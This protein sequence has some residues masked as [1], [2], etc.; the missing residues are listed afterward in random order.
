MLRLHPFPDIVI[1][2][3]VIIFIQD[4][5]THSVI[6]LSSDVGIAERAHMVDCRFEILRTAD[7]R[8]FFSGNEEDRKLRIFHSPVLEIIRAAYQIEQTLESVNRE[9]EAAVFALDVFVY[10]FRIDGKPVEFSS[11]LK[12]F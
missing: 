6:H 11:G 7:A 5:V 10:I 9:G 3:L 12:C 1:Y 4:L 8:I 2:N